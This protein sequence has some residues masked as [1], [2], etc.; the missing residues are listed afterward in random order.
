M[1]Y[2]IIAA[3]VVSVSSC[4]SHQL[5]SHP[6]STSVPRTLPKGITLVKQG[7]ASTSLPS[8]TYQ[9]YVLAN[10]LTVILHPDKSDP[11]VHV[12]VTYHVGSAREEIGKSGFAH[13]FEHMMFQ[14]S[15]NV[16]DQQHFK[17]VTESGG[18]VN[19]T[20]NRDR[21]NYYQTVPANELEKML[22]L[23]SDRMGFL[24]EAVSQ[25][26]F[27]IQRDTVKN[28]RAQ[29]YEN[30]PY[31]LVSETLATTLYPSDHPYSWPTIGRVADLDNVD[32]DVLKAFFLRWYGPNN[33]TLTIGGDID[34]RQTLRW[35]NKYFSDILPGPDVAVANKWPV[36]LDSDRFVTLEDKIEQPMLL[37][38][39]PT[40]YPDASSTLPIDML[41]SVL[42]QGR[43]SLLYQ[44]LVKPGKVLSANAYQ[45]CGELACNLQL[46]VLGNQGQ[47]LSIIRDE[48]LNVLDLLKD[49]GIKQSDLDQVKGMAEA[50]AVFSLQSVSGK[51]SQLAINNIMFGD[52]ERLSVWLTELSAVTTEEVEKAFDQ[53]IWD[54]PSVTLSVVPN[55]KLALQAQAQNFIPSI[56]KKT[57]PLNPPASLLMRKTPEKFNRRNVPK[58]SKGVVV[59][60]PSLYF[61]T[62]SNGIEII[63][64]QSTE[65]PTVA[66]HLILPAGTLMEPAG[67]NGLASLT[68]SLV[69]EGTKTQTSELISAELDLLG[70]SISI[71]ASPR[72]TTLT[73]ASLTKN[74]QPTLMIAADILF[75]PRLDQKDFDRLKKQAL[76]AIKLNHQMPQWQ[77]EQA[78]REVLYQDPWSAL[79]P[80]GTKQTLSALTLDDVKAFYANN[81]TPDTARV[82]AVGDIDKDTLLS[83]I[84]GLNQWQGTSAK[85]AANAILKDYS[86]PYI[87]LVDNPGSSQT[88]VQMVRH[89]MPYDA[90]GEMFKTELANFNLAGNF[91]SRLNLNL[92][93][94]K[95]FT[96][97]AAGRI[98]GDDGYGRIVFQTQVRADSTLETIKEMQKELAKMAKDGITDPELAFLRLASGQKEA[99]SYE[100]PG[101]KAQLIANIMRHKLPP[102]YKTQQKLIIESVT[103]QELN[104]LATKWFNPADYQIIVVGDAK[105]LEPQL[106]T[107]GLEIHRLSVKR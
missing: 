96:Y 94:D 1:R 36:T 57:D 12:D 98:V 54:Q 81:Y 83:S 39:W 80:E 86:Q 99:L 56:A 62:L 55:G 46:Y 13:F 72:G 52:P 41:A 30:R 97:G 71:N 69:G 48:I 23:E 107:I 31:G 102:D 89:A 47:D 76:E 44:Q 61:S 73:L 60:V 63:G 101:K 11:L 37:M 74:L 53:F 66:L 4:T 27:E 40:R 9:K 22:W 100:T 35:V 17:M 45:D 87:W 79:P 58:P 105:T 85:K 19:G 70:S 95:G 15:K 5:T 49:R 59:K 18:S 82:I 21:T 43:N 32:V 103:R 6:S 90:T 26:K 50:D 51:V 2:F 88:V 29:N 10:G 93:E 91:N 28:E 16:G 3:I 33:A 84:K 78:R 14:G 106:K 104:Q 24:L 7:E 25:K 8:I 92:R 65:T 20:T 75:N 38:S 67:K 77:A 34:V 42:G 64:A 68:A